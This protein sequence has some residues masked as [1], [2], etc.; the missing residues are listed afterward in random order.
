MFGTQNNIQQSTPISSPGQLGK[1]NS[2]RINK[3][4][5]V[6]NRTKAG[7][8]PVHIRI[9]DQNGVKDPS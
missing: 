2:N 6:T 3:V 9:E 5:A 4:A 7:L 8:S 1:S